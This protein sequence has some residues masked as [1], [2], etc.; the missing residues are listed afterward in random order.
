LI[1]A[2]FCVSPGLLAV[3]LLCSPAAAAD[4][5]PRPERDVVAIIMDFEQPY[6]E[7]SIE[8]MERE[9]DEIMDSCRVKLAFRILSPSSSQEAFPSLV[10]ARFR[11]NCRSGENIHPEPT[12]T[13][14][15]TH[16][17][18]GQILPFSEVDC[19]K[20]RSIVGPKLGRHNHLHTDQLFG[21]ALGRVLAH[22]L[23]HVLAKT[24]EH[25]GK[26]I[27]KPTLTVGELVS[28]RLSFE[29]GDS[30]RI[31]RAIH[32]GLPARAEQAAAMR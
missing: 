14:G 19:N 16:V 21:R 2:P 1:E 25:A 15:L 6:S 32:P 18:D 13:L 7:V 11:G 24:T 5:E 4:R 17:S 29:A 27:A 22:E 31:R 9:L 3:L 30:E 10:V 26:G 12:H 8:S 20:I 23:Y 28:G